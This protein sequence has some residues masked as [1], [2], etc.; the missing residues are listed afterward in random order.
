[1][2]VTYVLYSHRFDQIYIGHT[3]DLI[4]RFKS[5]NELGT[6]GHTSKYRPWMVVLVE[7]FET[8]SEAT[9]RN[10]SQITSISLS[11]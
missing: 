11:G 2:F 1:M 4:D 8:K 3:R 5:H 9:R 7:F 6:K 10:Q